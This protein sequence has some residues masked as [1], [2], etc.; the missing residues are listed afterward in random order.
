M[1]REQDSVPQSSS[2]NNNGLHLHFSPLVF[3]L[4]F[5]CCV[6]SPLLESRL[7]TTTEQ[8]KNGER[9]CLVTFRA[10][11]LS[12]LA[13][14]ISVSALCLL[15]S[16]SC[17]QKTTKHKLTREGDRFDQSAAAAAAVMATGAIVLL[18]FVYSLINQPQQQQ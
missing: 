1:F 13:G 7:W 18:I 3:F 12:L 14:A 10:L 2:S 9:H 17:G 16:L 11:F 15:L 8:Q 6:H 4:F 5:C